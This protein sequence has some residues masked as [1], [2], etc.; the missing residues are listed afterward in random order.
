MCDLFHL[1]PRLS[2]LSLFFFSPLTQHTIELR[3]AS[4]PLLWELLLLLLRRRGQQGHSLGEGLLEWR[5]GRR[6]PVLLG[7]LW[8]LVMLGW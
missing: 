8:R 4:P 6:H 5:K 3:G 2:L 1:R 7:Q